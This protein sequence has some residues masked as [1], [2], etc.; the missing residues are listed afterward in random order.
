[1]LGMAAVL[2]AKAALMGSESIRVGGFIRGR[3]RFLLE[4]GC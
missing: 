1:M 3:N 4:A 2:W